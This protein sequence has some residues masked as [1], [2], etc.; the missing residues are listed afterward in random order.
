LPPGIACED[1]AAAHFVDDSLA[2]IVADRPG[3]RGYLVELAEPG[4][5]VETAVDSRILQAD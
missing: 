1:G 4:T 3:A 5:A 2:E